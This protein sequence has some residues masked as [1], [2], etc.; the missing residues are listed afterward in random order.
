MEG[1]LIS[2]CSF[3]ESPKTPVMQL[4]ARLCAAL[5]NYNRDVSLEALSG[6][7]RLERILRT[8]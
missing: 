6:S 5:I 8:Y 1:G 7:A 3:Q 4:I 2:D